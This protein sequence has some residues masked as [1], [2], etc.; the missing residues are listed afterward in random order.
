M[1]L[2]V[3]EIGSASVIHVRGNLIGGTETLAV[4]EK[5]KEILARKQLRIVIDLSDVAWV[6]SSGLG[7]L[8]GC[9]TSVK[10]ANGEMTLTGVT[11]KVKNLFVITKLIT[12][13]DV[14][15]SVQEAVD[16]FGKK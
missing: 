16:A 10:N 15:E 14:F 7:M 3:K 11:E 1:K 2:D 9:L 13:F 6:N 4:H 8:M 12:L 5:V